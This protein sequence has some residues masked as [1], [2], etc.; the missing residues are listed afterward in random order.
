[1]PMGPMTTPYWSVGV[2]SLILAKWYH[3]YQNGLKI[4]RESEPGDL[5]S[6]LDL[7]L[8]SHG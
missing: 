3:L 2:F 7:S 4:S 5:P 6:I 1:M 8:I